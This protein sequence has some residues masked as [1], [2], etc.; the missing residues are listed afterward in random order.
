MHVHE[1]SP[2]WWYL[3]VGGVPTWHEGVCAVCP[4]LQRLPLQESVEWKKS[5]HRG[6]PPSHPLP[7]GGLPPSQGQS[8]PYRQQW[9]FSKSPNGNHFVRTVFWWQFKGKIYLFWSLPLLWWLSSLRKKNQITRKLHQEDW[10]IKKTVF[11]LYCVCVWFSFLNIFM[12][13][14]DF[15][16]FIF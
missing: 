9:S 3:L 12:F 11:R 10:K 8:S 2:A 13:N 1:A 7:A 16:H 15:W 4:A 5:P 6:G 14:D